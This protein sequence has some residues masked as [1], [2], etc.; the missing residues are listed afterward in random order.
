MLPQLKRSRSRRGIADVV[1]LLSLQSG[2]LGDRVALARVRLLPDPQRVE[3][4]LVDRPIDHTSRRASPSRSTNRSRSTLSRTW[5]G[6]SE[7]HP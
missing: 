2:P 6:G 5:A 1:G 4:G 7:R 3:L